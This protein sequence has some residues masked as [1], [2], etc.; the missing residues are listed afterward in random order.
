MSGTVSRLKRAKRN[1]DVPPLWESSLGSVIA[2]LSEQHTD[3]FVKMVLGDGVLRKRFTDELLRR[4]V[5]IPELGDTDLVEFV[6]LPVYECEPPDEGAYAEHHL[7]YVPVG[8]LPH[9]LNG[10]LKAQFKTRCSKHAKSTLHFADG[11]VTPDGRLEFELFEDNPETFEP[12]IDAY[13]SCLQRTIRDECIPSKEDAGY[14]DPLDDVDLSDAAPGVQTETVLYDA[15][16]LSLNDA[17]ARLREQLIEGFADLC[18]L[19]LKEDLLSAEMRA[20]SM[21]MKETNVATSTAAWMRKPRVRML[22]H[23]T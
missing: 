6:V 16:D 9:W 11:I 15:W 4:A 18:S 1:R 8:R 17:E 19:W 10:A 5:H 21:A 20:L 12:L 14:A 2:N 13:I 7:R 22:L 3:D 23:P